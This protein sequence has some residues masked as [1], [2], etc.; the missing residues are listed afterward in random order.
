MSRSIL[1]LVTDLQIGGTPTVVREL[2]TR[3]NAP[4]DVQVDVACLASSGPVAGQ[5]EAAGVRVFPLNARCATDLKVF[6]ALRQLIARNHYDTVFS[7]LMH[8]NTAAAAV[9]PF[10]R[11][12]R[13]LQSIQTTQRSPRWHWLI[14]SIVHHA[15][16][17]VVVPSASVAQ[18][19]ETWSRVPREKIVVIPNAIDLPRDTGFQP[20]PATPTDEPS[21]GSA[22]PTPESSRHGLETRV[23]GKPIPIG[24]IGRLDPVKRI[25]DLLEAVRILAGRVHLHVFGEGAERPHLES[26]IRQFDLKSLATLHGSVP[27]PQEALSQVELL[28]LPSEA[29]GFGLVLIEAMAAGVPVVATNVSGIRDVVRHEQTGLLVAP[30]APAE[31]ARAIDRILI[32]ADLRQRLVSAAK[33]DVARRFTW[34][35]VLPRYRQLLGLPLPLPATPSGRPV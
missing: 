16:E 8:A 30:A 6:V 5:L 7:F 13:F 22:K 18:A 11:A 4:P 2:A 9:A 25:P 24:F 31:L 29:E 17:R 20:M 27:D 35:V 19:A 34:D 23:T 10:V 28:V 32:D 1:L 26:L 3:L 14:Q 15:A 21:R 33:L 12:V